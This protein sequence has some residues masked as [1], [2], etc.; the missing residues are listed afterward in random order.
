M[1]NLVKMLLR[2]IVDLGLADHL[3][4]LDHFVL[5]GLDPSA[6]RIPVTYLGSDKKR[7]LAPLRTNAP[8]PTAGRPRFFELVDLADL[9]SPMR[10]NIMPFD[11]H[12]ISDLQLL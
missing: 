6:V 5:E 11:S 3:A 8:P 4:G 1:I 7:Y 10:V 9:N 12:H 2:V